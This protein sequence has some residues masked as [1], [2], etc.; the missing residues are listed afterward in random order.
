MDKTYVKKAKN[1]GVIFIIYLV[2]ALLTSLP[3]YIFNTPYT[4]VKLIFY[5]LTVIFVAATSLITA[6]FSESKG[7]LSGLIS[8]AGFL[9][10]VMIFV[11]LLNGFGIDILSFLV[12]LPLMLGAALIAGMIGINLK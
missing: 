8:G 6:Y 11:I 5:I 4:T 2:I 12:K 1:V 10:L 3:L 7:W 9:L